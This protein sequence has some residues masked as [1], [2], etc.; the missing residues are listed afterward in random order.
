[1]GAIATWFAAKSIPWK[2]IGIG[3]VVIA[4]LASI[5]GG[6]LYVSHLQNNLVEANAKLASEQVLRQEANARADAIKVQHDSQ[7]IRINALETQRSAIASE[8]MTLR[9][10]IQ[11]MDIEEDIESDNAE[12]ADAAV[13]SFN[14][15]N[16]Q[17][18]RL[19]ERAS[20]GDQ[21]RSGSGAGSEAGTT[22]AR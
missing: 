21:V 12:K 22:G 16:R 15:H 11:N 7:V 10:T 18:N 3:L 4:I 1:M 9:N 20:G 6:Y 19:L 17:L 5:T 14:A 13:A 2:W 8:V